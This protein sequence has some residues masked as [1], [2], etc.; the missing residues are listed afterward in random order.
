[1]TIRINT[2]CPRKY[3]KSNFCSRRGAEFIGGPVQRKSALMKRKPARRRR[4]SSDHETPSAFTRSFNFISS[5]ATSNNTRAARRP[6]FCLSERSLE[7]VLPTS[8]QLEQSLIR[9]PFKRPEIK[10]LVPARKRLT[11]KCQA[12]R[13]AA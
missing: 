4:R 11:W 2:H 8:F 1:M 9:S 6:R 12:L 10:A 13:I 3:S 5:P 7:A